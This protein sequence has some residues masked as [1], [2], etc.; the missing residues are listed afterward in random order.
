[1]P[2]KM[3]IIRSPHHSPRGGTR[4]RMIV[5]HY[6]AGSGGVVDWFKDPETRVSSH[7]V[8]LADGKVVQMVDLDRAAWHAGQLPPRSEGIKPNRSSIGIEIV[9]WGFVTPRGNGF[10]SCRGSTVPRREVVKRS[11]HHWQ[12]YAEPAVKAVVELVEWLCEETGIPR[13]FMFEGQ[14]GFCRKGRRYDKVPYYLPS[15][16]PGTHSC[17]ATWRF[18]NNSGICG[19][20]HINPAK[21]DPGPHLPWK[22]VLG[23]TGGAT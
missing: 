2:P 3:R 23:I 10:L 11:G 14:R 21:D 4:V 22:E 19:H 13:S 1:M 9:N 15:G 16:R 7:Y 8:V 20:C 18:E 17:L 6:T 5:L 12:R